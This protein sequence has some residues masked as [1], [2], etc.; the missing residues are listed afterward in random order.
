M[1]RPWRVVFVR[2]G[3]GKLESEWEFRERE[4]ERERPIEGIKVGGCSVGW[5]QRKHF[6]GWMGKEGKGL[7]VMKDV[8][9]AFIWLGVQSVP[10]ISQTFAQ[11]QQIAFGKL[12]LFLLSFW[13]LNSFNAMKHFWIVTHQEHF[14]ERTVLICLFNT[15]PLW[16][17]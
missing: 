11:T 10:C 7:G 17:S 1:G 6:W 14:I 3:L 2:S 13:T 15:I 5:I 12:F 16:L 9:V 4:R 8:Q